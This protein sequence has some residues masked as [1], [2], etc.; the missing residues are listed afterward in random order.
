[1]R[2]LS[3]PAPR[4]ATVG[5]PRVERALQ[6]GGVRH[7]GVLGAT[8]FPRR[9]SMS[10]PSAAAASLTMTLVDCS[11]ACTWAPSLHTDRPLG[12]LRT[13]AA[14]AHPSRAIETTA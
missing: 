7:D 3:I 2:T 11:R 14:A 9:D 1:M 10:P 5:R 8:A 6:R 13:F 4:G 12:G